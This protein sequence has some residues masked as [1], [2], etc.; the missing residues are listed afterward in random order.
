MESA[1]IG[2][3]LAS[4][5]SAAVGLA[6]LIWMSRAQALDEPRKI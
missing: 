6:L 4:L 2:I 5:F 3:F 1:K